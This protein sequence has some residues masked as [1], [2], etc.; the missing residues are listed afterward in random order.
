MIGLCARESSFEARESAHLRM[1]AVRDAAIDGHGARV[2]Y[3]P[4]A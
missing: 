3:L 4:Y 2:P 1:T